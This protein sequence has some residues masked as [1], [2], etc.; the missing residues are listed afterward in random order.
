MRFGEQYAAVNN[1]RPIFS[2]E[3]FPPKTESG[4]KKIKNILPELLLLRPDFFTV[5]YGAMGTTRERTV[6]IARSI[7]EQHGVETACHLTCVGST[8]EDIDEILDEIEASKIQNIVA[9]RGDP[10]VGE[11][12]FKAVEGGYAHA[13][14]LVKHIRRRKGFGVA[15]A[16]YPEKH[17]EARD[18]DSDLQFLKEKVQAG[19]DVVVTQLFYDN[20][21]YFRFVKQ[22]RALGIECPIIP[23]ILPIVSARQILR[24][25][26]MCGSR[27]PKELEFALK[28][29]G[30]DREAAK[31]VGIQQAT[32]QVRDLLD[33]GVPG[34][35]F[36]V[37]NTSEHMTRIF[38]ALPADLV[39]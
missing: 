11:S 14:D 9:L 35:H 37:M 10:P 2:F 39:R 17:V 38:D 13:V 15:V 3:L 8:A 22:A 23:G 36:Y 26:S 12:K 18:L 4:M 6:E 29:V 28:D 24:I 31:D 20:E 7:K 5:T 34:V 16:G 25:T 19:A 33:R 30:E 1:K 32:R 21:D 27:I